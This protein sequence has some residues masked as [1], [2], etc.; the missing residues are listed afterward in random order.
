MLGVTKNIKCNNSQKN[1]LKQNEYTL[2]Y[3]FLIF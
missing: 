2:N 1:F 3:N